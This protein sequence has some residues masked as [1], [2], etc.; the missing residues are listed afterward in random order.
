MPA[1]L[2]LVVNAWPSLSA[3]VR[4]EIVRRATDETM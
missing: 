2:A 4:A 3:E 1:D